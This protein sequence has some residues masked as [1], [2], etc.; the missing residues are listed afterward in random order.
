MRTQAERSV[1]RLARGVGIC[2]LAG[3]I[4]SDSGAA[5]CEEKALAAKSPR[6]LV[7]DDCDED[8]Q[9]PPFEDAVLAFDSAGQLVYR[10]GG[11]NVC[12]SVGAH[13]MISVS[14]DGKFFVARESVGRRL[15]A[16]DMASGDLL[17]SVPG[18]FHSAAVVNGKVCALTSDGT[19]YGSKAFLLDERG[20]VIRTCDV[21]GLDVVADPNGQFLWVIGADIKK[22]DMDLNVLLIVNPPIA[23]CA[24]S[25]D[26]GPNGSVWITGDSGLV[27]CS[28]DGKKRVKCQATSASQKWMA[29]VPL[30]GGVNPSGSGP[31]SAPR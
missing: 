29:V 31:E 17:W 14:A 18:R 15:L 2:L 11:L 6:V 9:N 21:K 19:I 30:T 27:H 10:V 24:V 22:C 1:R 12:Q 28:A 16:Y 7:L 26:V 4:L 8:Y 5:R 20:T 3:L 23:W 25:A 13:R